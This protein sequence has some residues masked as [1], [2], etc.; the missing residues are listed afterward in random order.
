MLLRSPLMPALCSPL[1]SPFATIKGGAAANDALARLFAIPTSSWRM[2]MDGDSTTLVN[3]G[4]WSVINN[5]LIRPWGEWAGATILNNGANGQTLQGRLNDMAALYAFNPNFAWACWLINDNRLGGRTLGQNIADL[6]AYRALMRANLPLCDVVMWGHNALQLNDPQGYNYVSPMPA[7]PQIYTDQGRNAYAGMTLGPNTALLQ[8]QDATG[9]ISI[10]NNPDMQD[11]LHPN[12]IGGVKNLGPMIIRTTPPVPP[13]NLA[14]SAAAWTSN[15]NNPWT[16]Y[17]RALEDTRYCTLVKTCLVTTFVDISPPNYLY[18]LGPRWDGTNI[19][20]ADIFPGG[21]FA[22]PNGN[23]KFTGF[24][25]MSQLDATQIQI[26]LPVAGG[27]PGN[28]PTLA[29]AKIYKLV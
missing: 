24:E 13:I 6:N 19:L 18:Y 10:N 9:A 23:Y 2:A 25:T 21:F 29:N 28:S 26:Q 8:K 15:P 11:Q 12:D 20:V 14:A 3:N 5:Q 27:A 7:G 22:T 16:V 17:S 1:S 4:M